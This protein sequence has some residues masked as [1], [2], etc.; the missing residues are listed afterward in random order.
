MNIRG[1]T[2]YAVYAAVAAILLTPA[3]VAF[4]GALKVSGVIPL[5]LV[6]PVTGVLFF[7]TVTFALYR[8]LLGIAPPARW[9]FHA[10]SGQGFALCA[11]LVFLQAA[12]NV[13]DGS[14]FLNLRVVSFLAVALAAATFD[15]LVF[16]SAMFG[17]LRP[18]LPAA[19][20]AGLVSLFYVSFRAHGHG[21]YDMPVLF[22]YSYLFCGAMASGTGLLW[23]VAA[24]FA[25]RAAELL[26]RFGPALPVQNMIAA[27][28]LLSAFA[29]CL[30]HYLLTHAA[31]RRKAAEAIAA[32]P[33]N[34]L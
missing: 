23:L 11:A 28:M 26:F 33:A 3:A 13:F 20:A 29:L 27:K 25:V 18:E 34:S 8:F 12:V 21:F 9:A 10:G 30:G 15:E 22:A 17:G 1:K 31:R 4:A 2:K 19:F 7:C 14:F 16:R 6:K 24:A 32:E 5:W